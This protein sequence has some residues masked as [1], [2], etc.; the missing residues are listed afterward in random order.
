LRRDIPLD[1]PT[2]L[3]ILT[4]PRRL[5]QPNRGNF[6]APRHHLDTHQTHGNYAKQ[7]NPDVTMAIPA[8]KTVVSLSDVKPQSQ[9]ETF[10]NLGPWSE[11]SWYSSLASP[12]YN[13]SHKKLR[14]ALRSYIDENIKP[15]M[16]EW[17]EKGEA[18]V[19][20]R[21]KW[22][23]TGFA[24]GDVPEPYRP[25]D[26]PGPAGIPVGEMDVFHLLVSTDEGSRI[27]GGVGTALAGGSVI[28]APP[29]IHHGTEEQKR[30]WLPG[31]FN[32]ET[33]FCLGITEPSGGV[34]ITVS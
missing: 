15:Y 20:E 34:C 13:E 1:A 17:E 6:V 4:T 24:F 10:G 19:E 30:K 23:K 11:P 12:Y 18:P 26:V 21:M 9:K 3:A 28:G 5:E 16:L 27:E 32:W 14:N 29:I 31:L 22:A 25:K 2:R 33:S 8:P 7:Y